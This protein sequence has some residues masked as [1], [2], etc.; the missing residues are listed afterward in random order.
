MVHFNNTCLH[1]DA[2]F[3]FIQP[4]SA[5]VLH[6]IGKN[7]IFLARKNK[8]NN[9]FHIYHAPLGSPKYEFPYKQDFALKQTNASALKLDNGYCPTPRKPGD[10]FNGPIIPQNGYTVYQTINCD[11][12]EQK[13]T[14][15][16]LTS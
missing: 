6:N 8:V 4:F 12:E 10:T 9:T 13:F 14:F 11:K 1:P 3:R 7:G 16:K 2:Q 15:G 5:S